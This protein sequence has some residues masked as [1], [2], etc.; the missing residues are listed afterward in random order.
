MLT[1]N[2]H[3]TLKMPDGA[4]TNTG[5]SQI[6][7][8]LTNIH[9]VGEWA[10]LNPDRIQRTALRI[11][12]PTDWE[13]TWLAK[14]GDYRGTLPK[15]VSQYLW[16]QHRVKCPD[17]FKAQIG[18]I[19]KKHVTTGLTYQYDFVDEIDW[20]SGDFGDSGSCYWGSNS[21]AIDILQDNGCYAIRFFDEN[22]KGMARA[23]IAPWDDGYV[24]FNGYGFPSNATVTAAKVLAQ[25]LGNWDYRKV[26]LTNR[27][28][29]S[30]VLYI[31]SGN[32]YLVTETPSAAQTVD[33]GFDEPC[34]YFCE[35]CNEC[36]NAD[37]IYITPDGETYCSECFY[38]HADSCYNCSET[39]YLDDL[40]YG[41][42][43]HRYCERCFERYF[44]VCEDCSETHS[45][46][47]LTYAD[48]G[49]HCPD[50]L[51]ELFQYDDKSGEWVRKP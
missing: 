5:V 28:N 26:Y 19:A 33:L 47:D 22:G 12:L 4:I 27:G 41:S 8:L 9:L 35:D 34:E 15:R 49:V 30:G 1:L 44:N 20:Q 13:W 6:V 43:D 40:Y 39:F 36:L 2:Q 18:N 7:R 17:S 51:E 50:C 45:H 32:G 24:V 37:D 46:D 42:D 38:E 16:K 48:D 25:H 31:N 3:F 21:S 11:N 14:H 29:T 10:T 23:W